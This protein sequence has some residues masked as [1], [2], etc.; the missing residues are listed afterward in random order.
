MSSGSY[1][2]KDVDVPHAT[3][4][5]RHHRLFKSVCCGGT[6]S[7]LRR[8]NQMLREHGFDE[9]VEARCAGFWRRP[10]LNRGW[11][12]YSP[13]ERLRF[14]RNSQ[15]P[16]AFRRLSPTRT[17]RI[18]PQWLA[19]R[20]ALRF[21]PSAHPAIFPRSAAPFGSTQ[22]PTRRRVCVFGPCHQLSVV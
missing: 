19:Q 14:G 13:L 10:D 15:I 11:S 22:S 17:A 8:L 12:F 18:R 6:E 9:F 16:S 5:A 7:A 20:L 1:A 4:M 3:T 21:P 2:A